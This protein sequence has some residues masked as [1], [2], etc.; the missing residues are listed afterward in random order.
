MTDI[1]DQPEQP[2]LETCDGSLIE[3]KPSIKQDITNY[4]HR[5]MVD[6]GLFLIRY[7][8][9][10]GNMV[11]HVKTEWKYTFPNSQDD[12]MQESVKECIINMV[13]VFGA[14][15]HS[16]FSAGYTIPYI[17]KALRFQ[18]FSPLTGSDDEWVI[19]DFDGHPYAQ[20]KRCGNVFKDVDGKAYDINGKVFV[21]PNGCS[22]TNRNSRVYITFPYTPKTEYIAVDDE[23]NPIPA[24]TTEVKA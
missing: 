6:I 8:E 1:Q 22:Y 19:H 9:R 12:E 7:P 5:K 17:E 20:N 15:G 23:G 21:E 3:W 14:E 18:P 24:D 13:S 4:I 2:A 10:N 16:G 11:N